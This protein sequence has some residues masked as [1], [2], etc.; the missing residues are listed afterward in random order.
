MVS[1]EQKEILVGL[2]LGDAHL[3]TQTNG[4]SYRL[5]VSQSLKHK[6]YLEHLYLLFK[7]LC[8]KPPIEKVVLSKS[9]NSSKTLGFS[10]RVNDDFKY[11]A[12]LF[13]RGNIKIVPANLKELL[14]CKALAYWFM[15]DGS[16]KSKQSKGVILN[17]QAFTL[18]EVQFVC[19]LLSNKFDLKASPRVQK[20]KQEK[21]VYYQIYIS[22]YS[23]EKFVALVSAYMQPSMLYKIP[24]PRKKIIYF[25]LFFCCC[26]IAV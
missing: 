18:E 26:R 3:E 8:N 17:T 15:D 9:A 2:L 14:T 23:Y 12:N 16:I 5:K 22:G 25:F 7:N 20:S 19:E 1:E 11:F 24:P 13:Y 10:T 4:K 21:K 6:K